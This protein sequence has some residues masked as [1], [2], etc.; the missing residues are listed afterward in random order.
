MTNEVDHKAAAEPPLDC[1][2]RPL[3]DAKLIRWLRDNLEWDGYGYWLPEVCVRKLQH[4]ENECYEPT[5]QEFR[6]F[7]SA[8]VNGS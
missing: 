2:V 8:K 3:S 1:R 6:T 5:M 4:G 7:L